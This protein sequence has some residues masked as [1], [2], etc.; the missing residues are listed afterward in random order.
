MANIEISTLSNLT[1]VDADNDYLVIADVSETPDQLKRVAPK[2]LPTPIGS[3]VPSGTAGS[4]LFV[5]SGND[6]QQDNA[7]FQYDPA[8]NQ[9][10][11]TAGASTDTPLVVKAASGQTA[12]LQEWKDSAG[13]VMA[14]ILSNGAVST[15]RIQGPTSGDTNLLIGNGSHNIYVRVGNG[16]CLVVD[17]SRRAAVASGFALSVATPAQIT[18]DQNNFDLSLNGGHQFIRLSSD[19]NRSITG[20]IWANDSGS[21]PVHSS[22]LMLVVVN[23]GS[24]NITLK[25]ENASST[26]GNRM[27]CSTGA[28]IVLSA[29]QA[30]DFIYDGVTSRWRVFKRN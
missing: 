2:D 6:L 29:N 9:L 5:G 11:L 7:G 4:V 17:P 20:V 26:A 8:T 3:P 1:A 15:P 21:N 30:A 13:A 19:A 18:A 24:N 22:G 23:V 28:D 27:I 16:I 10:K 14:G 12:N 25:H